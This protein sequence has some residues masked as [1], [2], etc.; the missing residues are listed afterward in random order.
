MRRMAFNLGR[1]AL[2]GGEETIRH[3][4]EFLNH[5]LSVQNDSRLV[6]TCELL[7]LRRECVFLR[8][9][10]RFTRP[11]ATLIVFYCFEADFHSW[12]CCPEF[13]ECLHTASQLRNSIRGK[14]A[15]LGIHSPAASAF[16]ITPFRSLARRPRRKATIRKRRGTGLV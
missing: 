5:P 4:R 15:D 11:E 2:F 1:P 10:V 3:C 9:P 12:M 16:R 8:P 14:L 7:T 13:P 6:A